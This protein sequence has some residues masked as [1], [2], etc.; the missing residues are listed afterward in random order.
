MQ[1]V[2]GTNYGF[3]KLLVWDLEA[4]ANFYKAVAGVVELARVEDE[5]GGRKIAE[6]M[7][8]PT[9]EGA[10]TF[11]LLKFLD[12]PKPTNDEVIV[13]FVTD[14]ADAFVERAVAAGGTVVDAARDIPAHGVRVAFVTDVEGHLIEVAQL[15]A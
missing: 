5:I 4:T 14:N 12:A 1:S 6:I 15:L 9:H 8:K 7:F 13:G 3:T 11:V 10:S 2:T